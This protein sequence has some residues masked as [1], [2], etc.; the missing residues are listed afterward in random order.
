MTKP[1]PA[2]LSILVL[3]VTNTHT[4][5]ET[6]A[7]ISNKTPEAQL[8]TVTLTESAETRL[9][10]V[11]SPI[12]RKTISEARLYG[13]ELVL[14]DPAG[15]DAQ[16]VF[17]LLPQMTPAE[18]LHLA[19]AQIDADG[20][21]EKV[22]VEFEAASI[23]VKRATEL[24]EN[25]VG[26]ARSVDDA[27]ARLELARTA[28]EAARSKRELLG[29]AVLA[30]RPPPQLWVKV[31]VYVGDLEQI[32]REKP[33]IVGGLDGEPVPTDLTVQ[34]VE[35]PPSADPV[36]ATVDLFFTLDNTDRKRVPGQRV[37]VRLPLKTE[38]ESLVAPHAAVLYDFEGGAWVYE[39]LGKQVYAR[40][41]VQIARVIDETAVLSSGPEAGT[42]VV[43]DG[44]A[45][46]FGTEFGVGK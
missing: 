5:E 38:A 36:A 21:L 16:S 22:R 26:S 12:E 29:P 11:T 4:A 18:R 10:I 15:E 7:T 23:E 2:C 24:L 8:A 45:E 1:I 44:A 19:E 37:G 3:F 30:T 9:G 41:R 17:S 40:R 13:G 42:P 31:P 6:Q 43:T 20:A 25:K 34:P 28:M 46:L 14:P 35:A 39:S 33:A 32:D 27:K